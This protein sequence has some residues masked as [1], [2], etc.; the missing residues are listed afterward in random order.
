M[1]DNDLGLSG[2]QEVERR[3][4]SPGEQRPAAP[5]AVMS[6]RPTNGR[7]EGV[8]T[9]EEAAFIIYPFSFCSLLFSLVSRLIFFFFKVC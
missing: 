8:D 5:T 3:M 7:E 9:G 2:Q 6:H 1:R 4:Q